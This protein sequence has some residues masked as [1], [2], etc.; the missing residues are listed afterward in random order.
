MR[1]LSREVCVVFGR[2]GIGRSAKGSNISL[3]EDGNDE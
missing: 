3:Q 2:D 1:Y